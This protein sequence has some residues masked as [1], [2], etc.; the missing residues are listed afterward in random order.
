M[1]ESPLTK[2]DDL[3]T[4]IWDIAKDHIIEPSD[5]ALVFVTTIMNRELIAGSLGCKFYCTDTLVYVSKGNRR[6]MDEDTHHRMT[7]E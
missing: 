7:A 6:L 3:T 5:R 1:I 2:Q 4:H